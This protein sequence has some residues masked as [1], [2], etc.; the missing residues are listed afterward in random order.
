MDT[1]LL[2]GLAL[3]AGLLAVVLLSARRAGQRP[4]SPDGRDGGSA[5]VSGDAASS[6]CDAGDGGSCGGGD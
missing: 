2:I 6:S 3:I 5:V 4:R 1:N